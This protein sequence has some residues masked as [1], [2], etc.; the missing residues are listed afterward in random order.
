MNEVHITIGKMFAKSGCVPMEML[1]NYADGSLANA[2]NRL[3]ELHI[4][5]CEFCDIALDGIMEAGAAVYASTVQKVEEAVEQRI[6]TREMEDG[7]VIEFRP[8]INPP[9]A[10]A[11]PIATTAR[12]GFKKILPLIG[13]AASVVLIVTFGIFFMSDSGSKIADRNFEAL[14][15]S[16]RSADVP[17]SPE[18]GGGNIESP[19]SPS[20]DAFEK[21]LALYEARDFKGAASLFDKSSEPKA[22][23]YAGDCFYQLG[24]F[25]QAAARY[26]VAIDVKEGFEDHAEYNLAMTFLKMD[27]IANAKNLLEKMVQNEEHVFNNKA[28]EVLHDVSGL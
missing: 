1:M 3:V 23:L 28:K 17:E 25:K 15:I 12:F 19:A 14:S 13:I 5:D 7:K 21:G 16:T 9:Q 27:E 26:Q 11:V 8:N 2:E 18:G 10:A 24:D 20:E 4:A 6:Q 22:S